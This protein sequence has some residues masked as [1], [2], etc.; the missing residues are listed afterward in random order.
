MEFPTSSRRCRH[1][2]GVPPPDGASST[3]NPRAFMCG[4]ST[5][6][7]GPRVG[8]AATPAVW[9][10]CGDLPA[11][12]LR[13]PGLDNPIELLLVLLAQRG[14]GETGIVGQGGLLHRTA[15][16][17][18]LLLVTGHNRYPHVLVA[19]RLI[20]VVRR[21]PAVMI[22]DWLR[23]AAIDRVVEQRFG[24]QAQHRFQHRQ[25]DV[26]SCSGSRPMDKSGHHG[27]GPEHP[28]G[29]IRISQPTAARAPARIA[30]E[31]GEAGRRLNQGAE[32]QVAAV[33][34]GLTVSRH[35]QH[36]EVGPELGERFIAQA[37]A[38]D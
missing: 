17:P 27:D 29:R 8:N 6:S 25:V 14:V 36:H 12:A 10:L 24:H 2:R 20:A 5:R 18:P 33:R 21:H 30:V 34:S 38:R 7:L 22:P 15:Q 19:L 28:G 3:W 32:T 37:H 11:V 4:S 35:R 1:G 16:R 26:L 13:G 23:Q 31:Q 9:Q